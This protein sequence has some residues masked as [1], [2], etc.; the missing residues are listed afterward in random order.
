MAWAPEVKREGG[1]GRGG[2]RKHFPDQFCFTKTSLKVHS[3]L[4]T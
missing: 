3:F 2:G 4:Q 1:V